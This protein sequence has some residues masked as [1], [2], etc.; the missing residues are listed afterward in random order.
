MTLSINSCRYAFLIKLDLIFSMPLWKDFQLL[1]ILSDLSIR[2][3]I[4]LILYVND[5]KLLKFIRSHV[6]VDLWYVWNVRFWILIPEKKYIKK[7]DG[8]VN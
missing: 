2:H 4:K 7:S 5:V 1:Q 3:L 8:M 6:S